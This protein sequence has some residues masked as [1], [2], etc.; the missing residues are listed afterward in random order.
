MSDVVQGMTMITEKAMR[1]LRVSTSPWMR[2]VNAI[3]SAVEAHEKKGRLYS[4]GKNQTTANIVHAAT[5]FSEL[6]DEIIKG[7][8]DELGYETDG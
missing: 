5:E 6:I 1:R 3:H 8:R 7:D 2:H 4:H